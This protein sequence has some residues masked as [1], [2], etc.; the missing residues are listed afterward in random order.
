MGLEHFSASAKTGHNVQEVFKQLTERKYT[1][2]LSLNLLNFLLAGI[3]Q[4]KLQKKPTSKKKKQQRGMLNVEGVDL[5]DD[6]DFGGQSLRPSIAA[7][8]EKKKKRSCIAF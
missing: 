4:Y 5:D 1:F 2:S 3:V 6:D 8:P 7:K